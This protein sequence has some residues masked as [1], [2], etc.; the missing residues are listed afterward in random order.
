MNHPR[1]SKLRLPTVLAIGFFVIILLIA[2]FALIFK[3]ASRTEYARTNAPGEEDSLDSDFE[4]QGKWYGLCSKNSVSSVE[5]F[6]KT[7]SED[8]ALQTHYAGFNW[9]KASLGNLKGPMLAY[10]YF[11][12]D[13][14]IFRKEKPI[15]LPAGD[16]YIT[17]GSRTVRTYCCNDYTPGP[18]LAES[19]DVG[20][21]VSASAPVQSSP[22]LPGGQASSPSGSAGSGPMAAVGAWIGGWSN[23]SSSP[24]LYSYNPG[25]PPGPPPTPVP[26]P[27]TGLLLGVG[28]A[29]FL[30]GTFAWRYFMRHKTRRQS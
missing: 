9:E 8:P 10:V 24:N 15:K 12:K 16:G 5:D 23:S 6:R 4:N 21:S 13:D 27:G 28:V 20:A 3:P 14:K 7:V 26:E 11:R 2:S 30:T 25:P 19:P 17:D 29:T 22:S 18:P 1:A